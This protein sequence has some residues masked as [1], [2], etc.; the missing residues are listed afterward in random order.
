MA[1]DL[2]SVRIPVPPLETQQAFCALAE[3]VDEESRLLEKLKNL[4][5]QQLFATLGS[6]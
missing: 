4:R 3:A 2:G 5:K 6:L 1:A